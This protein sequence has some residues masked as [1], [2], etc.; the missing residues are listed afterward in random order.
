M[1]DVLRVVGTIAGVAGISLG[2]LLFIYRDFIRKFL[3]ARVFRKL[4]STQATILIGST[5]AFTFSIAVIGIFASFAKDSST[6]LFVLLVVILLVFILSVLY[7]IKQPESKQRSESGSA[8]LVFV[9]IEKNSTIEKE[10]KG[11]H[12]RDFEY[13]A[14]HKLSFLLSNSGKNSLVVK[15]VK[16]IVVR[17]EAHEPK[18]E[19]EFI[20][21]AIEAGPLQV[22][23]IRAPKLTRART[24]Y[25]LQNEL[26]EIEP[27]G[28]VGYEAS[29]SSDELALFVVKLSFEWIDAVTGKTHVSLSDTI[30]LDFPQYSHWAYWHEREIKKEYE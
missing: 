13:K 28:V 2:I 8:R 22:F 29:F 16:L 7:I 5:I 1:A 15:K 24:E 14:L 17:Y 12:S 26:I 4:S 21:T 10:G 11:R 6:A 27:N 23:S 25:V 9:K 20:T 18:F 19:P 30:D 3:Q